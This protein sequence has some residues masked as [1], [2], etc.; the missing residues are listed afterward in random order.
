[1]RR[2]GIALLVGVVCTAA[3]APAAEVRSL[4]IEDAGGIPISGLEAGNA[5]Q[6]ALDVIHGMAQ[7]H[8]GCVYQMQSSRAGRL[9]T[10]PTVAGR[11]VTA[12]LK[13]RYPSR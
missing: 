4:Y 13:H 1:M 11:S 8:F 5:D 12:L 10:N 2:L 9:P 6:P 3:A 7:S